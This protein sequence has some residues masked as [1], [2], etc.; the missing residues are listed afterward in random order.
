MDDRNERIVWGEKNIRA[1]DVRPTDV[2]FVR[3]YWTEVMDVWTSEGCPFT[4][5]G[6]DSPIAQEIAERF[7]RLS[8]DW[9]VIRCVDTRKSNPVEVE[10][11]LIEF[12]RWDL[13]RVQFPAA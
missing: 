1:S 9:V 10:T 12:T 3:N 6:D 4:E 7:H 2:I 11:F 13:V 8:S 5:F